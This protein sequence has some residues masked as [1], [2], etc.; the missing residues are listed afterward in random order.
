MGRDTARCMTVETLY[1][2]CVYT[3]ARDTHARAREDRHVDIDMASGDCVARV[4]TIFQGYFEQIALDYFWMPRGYIKERI[5]N[6]FFGKQ[7]RLFLMLL[8]PEGVIYLPFHCDVLQGL[9]QGEG[10]WTQAYTMSFVSKDDA[11]MRNHVLW[12]AT[13]AI[14]QDTMENCFGKAADQAERYCCVHEQDLR[15]LPKASLCW[16]MIS[17]NLACATNYRFIALRRKRKCPCVSAE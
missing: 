9:A 16:S 4:R 11:E 6:F 5:G 3:L 10:E 14:S 17:S 13:C 2:A 8:N 15:M 1:G 7:L 12:N